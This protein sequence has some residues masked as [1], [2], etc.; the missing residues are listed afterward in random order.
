MAIIVQGKLFQNVVRE[1]P[2]ICS[3]LYELKLRFECMSTDRN[4]C[5]VYTHH[6]PTD[7]LYIISPLWLQP[8]LPILTWFN[9][10]PSM[11]K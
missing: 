10:N 7:L 9:F 8:G 3:A 4:Y 1:M 11:D 2:S 5:N 6:M